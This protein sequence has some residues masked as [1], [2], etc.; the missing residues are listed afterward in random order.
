MDKKNHQLINNKSVTIATVI[1]YLLAMLTFEIFYC[2]STNVT[3]II[4]GGQA[5]YYFS[6]CRIIVYI[7]FF[8]LYFVF[9]NKLIEE[10]IE[11]SKNK[12][13]RI[14]DYIA[15][16]L[17]VV[18]TVGAII[19][20]I[21]ANNPAIT[22]SIAIGMITVFLGAIFILYV[23]NSHIKNI[24][25]VVFTIG[26]VFTITTRYNHA[27]DEKKHFM[28]AFNIASGNF[29]YAKNPVTDLQVEQLPQLYKYTNNIDE[30]LS[31]SYKPQI[32]NEVN[33]EDV[34]STPAGYSPIFYI[35][36]AI[37]IWISKILGGSILD[38]YILGRIFNLILY[39]VLTSLAIKLLPYKKNIFMVIF[40]MP[41]MILL[42]ASYS[43]DG[44][45]MGFVSLFIAYVLKLK[46]EREY[47]TLKD[48]II[49][50]GFGVMLLMVKS[51]AYIMV[52]FILFMLP[53]WKTLKKN[54]KYLPIIITI[55]I[56]IC[57]LLVALLMYIKNTKIVAD[58]RAAGNISVSEQ[59]KY[60]IGNP[61]F[62]LK[63]ILV[64]LQDTLLNFNWLTALHHP[65][66]FTDKAQSVML[67]MFVFLLY[68]ALTE[69]DHH[70]KIKDKIILTISFF[71]V[72]FMTSM[73]LY[74]SFTQVGKLGIEGYQPRYLLPILPLVLM[75]I[76]HPK[77]K[78]EKSKNRNMNIQIISG[79]FII[80]GIMQNII[81]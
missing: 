5:N 6:I 45:C 64:H 32:T 14:F 31:Q 9:K 29:D 73:V 62:D 48:F 37:G 51:M 55:T 22:R 20:I 23:S 35:V 13:K 34:P 80:I 4:N 57:I 30:F 61:L 28:S 36:S 46:K 49:L 59:L 54:K 2:N 63:L 17:T 1:L 7:V 16:I 75:C 65:V 18:I 24:I 15:I 43:I 76:S 21:I 81:I 38:M 3:N 66:F 79:I 50:V 68:V 40:M 70:F 19:T 69:D 26:I 27:L 77:V 74:L 53:L 10:A 44:I 33:E 56:I 72:Y 52:A 47:I 60:I 71:L 67:L 42:A 58:T 39:G 78:C 25:V 12:Y 11:M 41:L 8:T